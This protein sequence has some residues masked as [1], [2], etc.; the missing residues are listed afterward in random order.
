MAGPTGPTGLTG[1]GPTGTW[2]TGPTGPT[3]TTG[4]T[5]TG[6]TGPTG[7]T[8]STGSTGSAG[9]PVPRTTAVSST[10]TAIPNVDNA[11]Q[12]EIAA[13][14]AAVTFLTPSGTPVDGQKLWIQLRDDGTP[15]T[16]TWA[17]AGYN[18]AS[19][20]L[21][22]TTEA[23]VYLQLGFVYVTANGLNKW[24]LIA[25]TQG[26]SGPT[27][28][29]GPTGA[30]FTG[31]TGP[32]GSVPSAAIAFSSATQNFLTT[33]TQT[34]NQMTLAIASGQMYRIDAMIPWLL[35]TATAGIT[36]GLS[37]PAARR[38]N[39]HAKIGPVAAA[40]GITVLTGIPGA[41]AVTAPASGAGMPIMVITSGTAGVQRMMHL[42][43]QLL[44]SGSG[45]LLFYGQAEVSNTTAK[46]L[47]GGHV[48]AWNIASLAI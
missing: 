22:S 48:I 41:V 24:Q 20:P 42:E 15:R 35:D 16:L 3:G 47:D 17:A 28:P 1:T 45:N 30:S 12:F 43:G 38:F 19:V 11:D 5:G 33:V 4:L 39:F 36:I 46:V 37:F 25:S 44:C 8:G 13:L 29:T 9:S 26:T 32:V 18:Q 2:Q 27:G 6:P 7:L 34:F 10:A 40:G 14:S 23:S 21:P 31:P